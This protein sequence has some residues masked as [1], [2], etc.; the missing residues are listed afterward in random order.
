MTRNEFIQQA[1]LALMGNPA[2]LENSCRVDVGGI[3]YSA[4]EFAARMARKLEHNGVA[5]DIDTTH[6]REMPGK[7]TER[8]AAVPRY[9]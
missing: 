9:F 5:F 6:L 7:E 2:F 3:D 8:T 4:A 1:T